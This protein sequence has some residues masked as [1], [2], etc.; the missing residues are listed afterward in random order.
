MVSRTW[1]TEPGA[2]E[3]FS[4]YMVW[5]ESMMTTWGCRDTMASCTSARLVSHRSSSESPKVPMR[6]ARSLICCWD[7]S[8]ET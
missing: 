5:M 6:F 2:E 3:T 7:S 8:P 1:E 4:L